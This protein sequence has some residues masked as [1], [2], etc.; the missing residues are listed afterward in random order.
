VAMIPR[1]RSFVM[2]SLAL[3]S[4]F[5]ESSLTVTPSVMVISLRTSGISGGGGG[6]AGRLAGTGAVCGRGAGAA[7]GEALRPA[8]SPRAAGRSGAVG[9]VLGGA[10]GR[11]PAV[12]GDEAP[13]V[14]G[15]CGRCPGVTPVCGRGGT[16]IGLCT[17]A[18]V[19]GTG[20]TIGVVEA[21]GRG[22]MP[23][24]GP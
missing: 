6:A 18:G 22:G 15:G 4:I 7:A 23:P 16:A 14:R 10:A 3:R 5:S 2:M 19:P 21:P 8:E 20:R 24:E 13:V 17:G 12:A 1:P 9:R 11:V